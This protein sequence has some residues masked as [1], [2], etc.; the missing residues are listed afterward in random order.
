[1]DAATI[2]YYLT[3]VS[4][5]I[6]AGLAIAPFLTICSLEYFR[7]QEEAQNSNQ[8]DAEWYSK[9]AYPLSQWPANAMVFIL[10]FAFYCGVLLVLLGF[11]LKA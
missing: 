4:S 2:A 11:P 7:E 1:M 8:S 10:F 3:R 5:L 6:L 9:R